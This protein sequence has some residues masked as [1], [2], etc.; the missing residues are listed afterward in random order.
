MR[1]C[2]D[3]SRMLLP[4]PPALPPAPVPSRL[5]TFLF[6]VCEYTSG[7]ANCGPVNPTVT[8]AAL[9]PAPVTEPVLVPALPCTALSCAA[10]VRYLSGKIRQGSLQV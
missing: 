3:P 5:A 4:P 9:L 2:T 1:Y 6:P 10:V 7:M 8:N